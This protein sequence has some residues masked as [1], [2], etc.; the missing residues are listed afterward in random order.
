MTAMTANGLKQ[1][2][3]LLLILVFGVGDNWMTAGDCRVTAGRLPVDAV[4]VILAQ[5]WVPTG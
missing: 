3:A 4:L 5:S 2:T 1:N